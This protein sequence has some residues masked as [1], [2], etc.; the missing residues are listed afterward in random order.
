MI[1]IDAVLKRTTAAAHLPVLAV[2]IGLYLPPTVGVTLGLGAVLGWAIDRGLR[3]RADEERAKRRG[4]LIA[5]GF[6]V[7]ESLVGVAMAGVIGATG[8]E[9]PL[10]LAG[11]GFVPVAQWISLAVFVAVAVWF[12]ARVR[13]AK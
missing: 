2:G 7:G 3:G 1:G 12:G 10:A 13:K 11:D 6:I 5:S 9:T 8:S 4:V